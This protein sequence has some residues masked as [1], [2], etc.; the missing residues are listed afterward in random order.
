VPIGGGVG[1]FVHIGKIP[2]KLGVGLF[3]NVVQPV[4]GGR[5]VVNAIGLVIF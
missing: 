1:K 4:G 2:T 5:L 3:Y